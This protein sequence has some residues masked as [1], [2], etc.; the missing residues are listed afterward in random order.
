MKYSP[1]FIKHN[2]LLYNINVWIVSESHAI[3]PFIIFAFRVH[4]KRVLLLN[5][6]VC[7]TNCNF[8][9]R[10]KLN[11]REISTCAFILFVF[12]T[13]WSL[14]VNRKLHYLFTIIPPPPQWWVSCVKGIIYT[15]FTR[16]QG[17]LFYIFLAGV[18]IFFPWKIVW[19]FHNSIYI[20]DAQYNRW[21]RW[22]CTREMITN[23]KS[24]RQ[25]N[26]V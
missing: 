1:F 18:N 22:L 25:K 7:L 12:M 17:T 9:P 13:R 11:W 23:N 21:Y 14:L 8:L 3:A 24:S 16:V 20:L 5:A 2:K 10:I 19:I 6:Y 4:N 26:N 15:L